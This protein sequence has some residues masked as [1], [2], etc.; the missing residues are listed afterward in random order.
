MKCLACD[1]GF[2]YAGSDTCKS[3]IKELDWGTYFDSDGDKMIT[4][5]SVTGAG[6]GGMTGFYRSE[7]SDCKLQCLEKVEYAQFDNVDCSWA[8]WGTSFDDEGQ[9]TCPEG[10]FIVGFDKSGNELYNLE[11]AYCCKRE[12]LSDYAQVCDDWTDWTASFDS[13]GWSKCPEGSAIAGLSR[14]NSDCKT[15]SCI[16]KAKCCRYEAAAPTPSPTPAPTDKYPIKELDWGTYFD[17]TGD[18]LTTDS[19]IAGAGKGGI[20]GLYRA[21]DSDCKLQCIEKV[22]YAQF[23]TV[24]CSWADWSTSFDNEGQ[25]ACPEGTFIEGF[26][27]S[28]NELYNLEKAYCCKRE[29]LSAYVSTCDA[30]TDWGT[31]FDS[32]GYSKCAKGSALAGLSRGNSECTTLNCIEKAKCCRYE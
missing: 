27:K 32:E 26:Q 19:S 25:S 2:L 9:S 3:P 11:R 1:A 13:E 31:S 7:G 4:D 18:K 21:G 6:Q 28:G 16:E 30:W 5:T 10:T 22:E 14:S 29:G 12:G 24:D 20:T 15:L 8:D 17:T 23:N